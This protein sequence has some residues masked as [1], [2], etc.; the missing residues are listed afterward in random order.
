MSEKVKTNGPINV[1]IVEDHAD[2]RNILKDMMG[3]SGRL[4]CQAAFSNVE[5]ILDYFQEGNPTPDIIILDLGLPGIDGIE[6][7]PILKATAPKTQILV[8]TVFDNKTRVFQALGAGASGYLIKSDDLEVTIQGI[9]DAYNGI[10]PL[11]AEIAQ[12]VFA[13]FSKFKPASTE[14]ELSDREI[15]VLECMSTGVSRQEAA[16]SLCISVHT[17]STHIKNIYRKLQVHNVSGAVSKAVEMG[18]F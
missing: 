12:M 2:Y 9:E 7:I 4:Q 6:A 11:S 13:T 16:D 10:A 18:I 3:V 8:L 1:C 14:K 5:D 15:D 17:V